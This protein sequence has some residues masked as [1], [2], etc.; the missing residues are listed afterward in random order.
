MRAMNDGLGAVGAV[1]DAAAG[2]ASRPATG[3]GSECDSGGA[4]ECEATCWEPCGVE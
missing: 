2:G 3:V 4:A 1:D